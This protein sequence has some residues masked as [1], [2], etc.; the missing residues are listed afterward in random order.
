MIR[1]YF[2]WCYTTMQNTLHHFV[3]EWQAVH[4]YTTPYDWISIQFSAMVLKFLQLTN[5]FFCGKSNPNNAVLACD[6][7]EFLISN[8]IA[9]W[10]LY[11]NRCYNNYRITILYLQTFIAITTLIVAYAISYT[12]QLC[13]IIHQVSSNTISIVMRIM[14]CS[15]INLDVRTTTPLQHVLYIHIHFHTI[16]N[17]PQI[18]H[19][20]IYH[21]M[22]TTNTSQ[23]MLT[24][25]TNQLMSENNTQWKM[26]SLPMK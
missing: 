1:L 23:T 13:I 21:N 18:Q 9:T 20:K 26:S 24:I 10:L 4:I 11:I 7:A 12:K 3:T 17:Y 25:I 6:T 2:E 5:F 15:E 16:K 19:E 22:L 8:Y 14:L